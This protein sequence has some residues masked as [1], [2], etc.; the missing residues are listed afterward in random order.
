MTMRM[1]LQHELNFRSAH[2]QIKYNILCA[3]VKT[4][5]FCFDIVND[6]GLISLILPD[7]L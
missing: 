5:S 1:T 2:L 4:S 6:M 3:E 7:K